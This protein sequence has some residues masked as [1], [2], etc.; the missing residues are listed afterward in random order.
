MHNYIIIH[1]INTAIP[2]SV[3]VVLTNQTAISLTWN[4][5][6]KDSHSYDVIWQRI[7]SE[8][9]SYPNTIHTVSLSDTSTSYTITGLDENSIY[10]ITVT[11]TSD[12]TILASESVL[13]T[14]KEA[15]L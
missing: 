12:A 8:D 10:N 13:G 5:T 15:G 1:K 3:S 14:T 11:I 4:S 6:F 7:V 2:L 9:C